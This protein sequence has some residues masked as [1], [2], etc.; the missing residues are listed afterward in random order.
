MHQLV[1]V[2]KAAPHIAS[3]D[4]FRII[5]QSARNNPSADI[6]G[7]LIFRDGHFL[8]MVEG[9]L[10]SLDGLLRVLAHDPRHH[11]IRVLSREPI[12]ERAFPKWRMRRVGSSGEAA[13][14]LEESLLSESSAAR[15]PEPVREF[16]Y[17]GVVA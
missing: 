2:S 16:L 8:Q 10:M 9:P 11:S 15:L 13:A 14:Q 4:V 17:G 6:T 5:E 12:E 3:E 7:F 1:Y